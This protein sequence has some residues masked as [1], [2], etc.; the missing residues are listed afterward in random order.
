MVTTARAIRQ[1]LQ[2]VIE[3]V[4]H[5]GPVYQHVRLITDW[6]QYLTLFKRDIGGQDRIRGWQITRGSAAG[7]VSL[8]GQTPTLF[9]FLTQARPYVMQLT[10]LS[11]LQDSTGSELEWEDV[12]E[13]VQDALDDVPLL[14][15]GG[16]VGGVGPS[17]MT[18][19]E[20]RQLGSVLCHYTE[21][22]VPVAHLRV[23]S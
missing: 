21:I 8:T 3:S 6:N 13:A 23:V 7:F 16:V 19:W 1:G 12:C 2:A 9:S 22:L 4:P 14:T 15:D 5:T 18:V 17:I 10:G 11:A 20:E